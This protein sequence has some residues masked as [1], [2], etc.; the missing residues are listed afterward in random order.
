MCPG[1]LE[2]KLRVTLH[3]V[4]NLLIS[5]LNNTK[6]VSKPS[7]S[8]NKIGLDWEEGRDEGLDGQEGSEVEVSL[9]G[10]FQ[11]VYF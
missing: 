11:P 8:V 4:V 9:T 7:I 3:F 1:I 10:S 5:T 6:L 2:I